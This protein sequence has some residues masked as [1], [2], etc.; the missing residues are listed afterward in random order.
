MTPAE[1]TS[2]VRVLTK[3]VCKFIYLFL[4]YI[5]S[6][7]GW[8]CWESVPCNSTKQAP[9]AI[10]GA[11]V[12]LGIPGIPWDLLQ[13]WPEQS[14]HLLVALLAR[15]LLAV[16]RVSSGRSHLHLYY[17]SA[18]V[19]YLCSRF[20]GHV[21]NR[22]LIKTPPTHGR[23]VKM[24]PTGNTWVIRVLITPGTRRQFFRR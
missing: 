21:K 15:W 12:Y 14:H 7:F 10:L 9:G 8:E 17:T 23:R 11:L 2:V 24:T 4:E 3:F 6:S 13:S 1:N 19:H 22:M 5:V 20:R 18:Q 16:N